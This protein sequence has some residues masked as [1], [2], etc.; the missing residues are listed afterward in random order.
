LP[1]GVLPEVKTV[2]TEVAPFAPGVR[3]AGENEQELLLGNPVQE[4]ATGELNAPP[5]EPTLA[6]KVTD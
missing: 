3:L 2:I 4:R 5:T 6:L 1:R